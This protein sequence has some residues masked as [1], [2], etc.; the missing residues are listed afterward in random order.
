MNL[1]VI[2]PTRG[3]IHSR[4]IQGL[5]DA[6]INAKSSIDHCNLFFSHDN[7]IPECFNDPLQEAMRDT[8]YDT[9]IILEEDVLIKPDT[10]IKLIDSMAHIAAV[11]YPLEEK[12]CVDTSMGYTLAGTGCMLLTR[13]VIEKVGLFRTTQAYSWPALEPLPVD[14][15]EDALKAYGRQDIDFCIRAQDAGYKI[16]IADTVDHLRVKSQIG[17]SK[18]N[19][20]CYD[21]VKLE[22][23]S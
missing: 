21:I 13:E 14:S 12:M 17:M 16:V 8:K 19:D 11:D 23:R 6:L 9:F 2:L 22:K 20:G 1:A 4:V 3:L 7:P 15:E 5:Y 18:T 10:I